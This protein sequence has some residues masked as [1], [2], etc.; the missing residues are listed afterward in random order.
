[1]K[2]LKD[3]NNQ[4]IKNIEIYQIY[5]QKKIFRILIQIIQNIKEHIKIF[6]NNNNNNNINKEKDFAQNF[7]IEVPNNR[8]FLTRKKPNLILK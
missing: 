3:K 8:N 6:N 2:N 7:A 5:F 1:M 4:L